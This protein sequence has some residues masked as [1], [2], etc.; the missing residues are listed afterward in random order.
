MMLHHDGLRIIAAENARTA[1]IFRA[2]PSDYF[3]FWLLYR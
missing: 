3:T 1:H 2:T